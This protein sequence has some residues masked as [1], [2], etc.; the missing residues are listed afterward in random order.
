[1]KCVKI[2]KIFLCLIAF[3]V[4]AFAAIPTIKITTQNGSDVTEKKYYVMNLELNDSDN[5]EYNI[6]KTENIDS[7]RVRGNSTS[8]VSKKPYRIKFNKKTSLFG[9]PKAKSWV[10]LAN[11]YDNTQMLNALA[12]ELGKRLGLEHTPDYRFVDVYVNN[13]YKGIYMLCDQVQVNENRV[14]ISKKDGWLVEFDYHAP[15]ADEIRFQWTW[16]GLDNKKDSLGTFVKSPDYDNPKTA[17]VQWIKNDLNDLSSK[18]FASNFPENG[19]RDL[20]DLDAMAKYIM[21]QKFMDNFDFNSQVQN[22][23]LPG[24]NY[25]YKDVG[26]KIFAGPLWD[27]DLSAGVTFSFSPEHFTTTG[28]NNHHGVIPTHTYYKRFFDDPVF[29][30]KWKKL[31]D[32][33]QKDFNDLGRVADSIAN[34][35]S[36]SI[37]NNFNVL[38]SNSGVGMGGFPGMGGTSYPSS[39]QSYKTDHVDK[40]KNWITG[41]KSF[42]STKINEMNIDTSKDL[43]VQSLYSRYQLKNQTE[44]LPVYYNLNGTRLG[45]IKPLSS[46]IYFVRKNKAFKRITLIGQE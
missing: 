39:L 6:S 32:A 10:L 30:A 25:H 21:V 28:D 38:S 26:T 46:G 35:I 20:I 36:P 41:R 16:N 40:L 1:M 3:S 2:P 29:L 17:D 27:F 23:F 5:P 24:S 13:N 11:Y 12:F 15:D 9:L 14:N 19:Y 43:P 42:F 45:N 37:V 31:W 18:M 8:G 4:V 33:H 34:Y 22:G 7:I 44:E